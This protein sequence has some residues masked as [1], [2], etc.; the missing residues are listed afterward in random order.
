V[1]GAISGTG[2]L[3]LVNDTTFVSQPTLVLTGGPAGYDGAQTTIGGNLTVRL[4]SGD[5]RL[6]TNS[7]LTLGIANG[8]SGATWNGYGRM[9]LGTGTTPVNQTFTGLAAGNTGGS[10]LGGSGS[11]ISFLAINATTNSTFPGTLGGDSSPDNRIGLIKNGPGQ[12]T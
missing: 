8:P 12:L 6:A 9:R 3:R 1:N 2:N 10:I 11:G 5:N 4:Q 7:A